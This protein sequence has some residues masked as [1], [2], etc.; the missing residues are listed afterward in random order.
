MAQVWSRSPRRAA[1]AT[2]GGMLKLVLFAAFLI[3]AA[4]A[5]A[6]SHGHVAAAATRNV[7]SRG[8]VG[9]ALADPAERA[10]HDGVLKVALTVRNAPDENG[11]MRYCYIDE[12]GNQ[13]PT[14]R[15][16]PGDTL[17]VSLKNEIALREPAAP[18]ANKA[19]T[20]GMAHAAGQAAGDCG[21]GPIRPDM[22][23]LHFHGL[24]LPPVCHQD[25]TLKTLIS[26]GDPPFEYRI[27]IPA[28][29]PPG[30]YW[31]HPH[32]HGITE[33]Q[34]LGG[35]SGA[36]VVEGIGSVVPRVAGL[37][38]RIFVVR[39]EPMPA[40]DAAKPADAMRPTKQ[41]TVNAVPVPYPEYLAPTIAM[42]PRERQLWRVVNASADTFLILTLRINGKRQNLNL[43]AMDGVPI[44]YGMP[45]A[46][47]YSPD[48]S[49]ILLSP[50]GRA[51]FVVTAP[52]AGETGVLQTEYAYR[53]P[54]DDN[55]PITPKTQPAPGVRAGLDDV[56]PKRPL[57][58]ILTAPSAANTRTVM[59]SA[60]LRQSFPD[61][62]SSRPLRK[63]KLFF[64]EGLTDPNDPKSA[65]LF[66]ITEDGRTPAAFSHDTAPIVV[67][68]GDVED[69]T[70]ENRSQEAHTFHVHQLHFL[71]VGSRGVG[72]EETT[73][74]DTVNLP[75]WVGYGVYPSV[76]LRMDFRDPN[77]AGTF[78]FHCHILQHVD[79]GMMGL[80]KI[81]PASDR[82]PAN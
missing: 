71:V 32:V 41:I 7:C 45:G 20:A 54:G 40:A 13:S 12:L 79:G 6:Q 10:S 33:Q 75:A 67:H 39:D 2:S 3:T 28:N 27:T 17:I 65:P 31:Y 48:T 64:S 49:S 44:H 21:G 23:N 55:G 1:P 18:P 76:T 72:W 24:A 63:R 38:E 53:G 51:E 35:L 57:V 36:I 81:V 15:V 22:T 68:Q 69:W 47:E 78:P 46:A 73:P 43:V 29:Q 11:N 59:A 26:P 19:Q 74:R 70:I 52:A 14:L 37:P 61:L 80:I 25:D 42:K 9:S 8:A 62:S 58:S 77:I 66:F 4:A 16:K 60:G 30:L 5:S 82:Q 50:A 56:D 34:V